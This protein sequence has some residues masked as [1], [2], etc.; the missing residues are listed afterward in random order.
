MASE[1]TLW[2][3]G[4]KNKEKQE[5]NSN[6]SGEST[7]TVHIGSAAGTEGP[8]IFLAKSKS[9]KTHPSLEPNFFTRCCDSPPES[10]VIM[11]PSAYMTDEAWI[12]TAQKVATGIRCIPKIEDHEDW[13]C[14]FSVDG[15]GSH[16]KTEALETF[17]KHQVL[18]IKEESD[19]SQVCQAHDQLG[20]KQDKRVTC[21]LLE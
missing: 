17:V 20:A 1:G 6:D 8:C 7:T 15:F 18:V 16:L 2:V 3:I 5:K 13:W 4:N 10:H 9:L 12:E 11:T 21:R 14:L 19:S